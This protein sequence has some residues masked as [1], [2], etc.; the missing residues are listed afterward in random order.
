MVEGD[1]EPGAAVGAGRG[2]PDGPALDEA[3]REPGTVPVGRKEQPVAQGAPPAAR[4]REPEA[5]PGPPA[6]RRPVDD[7]PAPS[8]PRD[9]EPSR[10]P[11]APTGDWFGAAPAAGREGRA[12]EPP[13]TGT[14]PPG[15]PPPP[16]TG[17]PPT[18]AARRSHR[19]A[20]RTP[21]TAA[22]RPHG[23]PTGRAA[24]PTAPT[25]DPA[26]RPDGPDVGRVEQPA[27]PPPGPARPPDGPAAGGPSGTDRG[28][29]DGA[30]GAGGEV[31]GNRLPGLRGGWRGSRDSMSTVQGVRTSRRMVPDGRPW[32]P[33]GGRTPRWTPPSTGPR[34]RR[35]FGPGRWARRHPGRVSGPHPT[36][37]VAHSA[38]PPTRR[39]RDP[40]DGPRALRAASRHAAMWTRAGAAT[41]ARP[42]ALAG[43]AVRRPAATWT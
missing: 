27:A 42:P 18:S 17:P 15:P 36:R 24:P 25:L 5:A 10:P 20:Q 16:R 7:R 29:R 40:A 13:P 37:A 12:T 4:E 6:A 38:R 14:A 19:A 1:P 32:M 8:A 22:P 31:V 43:R 21:P 39:L 26:R 2:R 35:R 34:P 3:G 11:L 28:P 9:P 41:R 23:A 33:L 30:G